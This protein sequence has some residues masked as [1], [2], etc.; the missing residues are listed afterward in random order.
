MTKRAAL[1]ALALLAAVPSYAGFHDVVRAVEVRTQMH[2]TSIPFLGL[3][4][5]AV[6]IVHPEGVYDFQLATFEGESRREI[7]YEDL[8]ATIRKAA[9]NGFRPLVQARSKRKGEFTYILA[10]P[11]DDD[12]I[13]FMLATHD[14]SD[15]VVIRAV[16][17]ADKMLAHIN[18]PH[19][20]ARLG[21][22]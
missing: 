4:R 17:D 6:W 20:F 10:K 11:L 14:H 15:T 3:A 1:F 9:G 8:T 2:P 16:I 12:R 13:E 21:S 5:L 19:S 22:K 7:D 18:E